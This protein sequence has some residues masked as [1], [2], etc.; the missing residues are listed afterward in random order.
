LEHVQAGEES[1][2]FIS[3][4]AGEEH[5]IELFKCKDRELGIQTGNESA[6]L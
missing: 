4:A 1:G 2:A 6:H 5:G 3:I